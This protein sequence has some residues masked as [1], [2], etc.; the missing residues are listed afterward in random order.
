MLRRAIF[1]QVNSSALASQEASEGTTGG[2]TE[3]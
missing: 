2:Y 1:F 3:G